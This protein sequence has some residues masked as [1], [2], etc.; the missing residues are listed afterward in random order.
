MGMGR[1]EG[2][3]DGY[4]RELGGSFAGMEPTS[5]GYR[6]YLRYNRSELY[7]PGTY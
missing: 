1:Q 3:G 7:T 6:G 4:K 5:I 2:A